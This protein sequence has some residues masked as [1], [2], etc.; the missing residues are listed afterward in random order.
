[1][2]AP[3]ARGAEHTNPRPGIGILQ[4]SIFEGHDPVINRVW[5][6]PPTKMVKIVGS[7]LPGD[8]LLAMQGCAKLIL[9]AALRK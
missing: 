1:M 7:A 3:L 2:A 8:F 5:F 6:L 4:T 9:P